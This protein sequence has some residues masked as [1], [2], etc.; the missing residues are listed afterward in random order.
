[1]AQVYNR[2]YDAEKW[3]KVCKDNKDI[4]TDFIQEY[5]FSD[6]YSKSGKQYRF[7]FA[8]FAQVQ[9]QIDDVAV[10]NAVLAQL[11][12]NRLHQ[13]G[14]PASSDAG[15]NLDQ[16]AVMVKSADCLKVIF[17]PIDAHG[18]CIILQPVAES[19]VKG[20]EIQKQSI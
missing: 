9:V 11:Q 8:V 13:A 14:L 4:I 6:L 2:I 15:N 10:V 5:K 18:V 19:Q 7:D 20:V 12:R 16:F 1:M 17:S 3:A